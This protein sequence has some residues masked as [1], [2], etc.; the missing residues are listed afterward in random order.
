M[1]ALF[2][3]IIPLL[4]IMLAAVIYARF[5]NGF[6]FWTEIFLRHKGIR[7]NGIVVES[8]RREINLS[9][10][11]VPKSSY[12][13]VVDV[14]DPR[15]GLDF[16]TGFKCID[17]IITEKYRKG[18]VLPV[19]IHPTKKYAILDITEM[20]KKKKR[21]RMMYEQEQERKIERLMKGERYRE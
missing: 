19:L 17:Y 16:R 20:S 3:T 13:V 14:R 15:S 7:S 21:D 18:S 9:S 4:L 5:Q 11:N 8:V 1:I 10:G 6:W 2:L 12:T